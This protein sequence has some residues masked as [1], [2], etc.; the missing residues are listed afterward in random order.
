[1][2]CRACAG[3]PPDGARFCPDCGVRLEPSQSDTGAPPPAQ[4]ELRRITVLFC[5]LVGS[6]ELSTHMDAEEFGDVI[7]RYHRAVETVVDL[8]DGTVVQYLGDGVLA[9]FGWP[10][11]HDDDAEH[12]V[13][14]AVDITDAVAAAGR[15]L[16]PGLRLAVRVGVHSGPVMVGQLGGVRR[17]RMAL[18][19][20]MNLAARVQQV[21]P[22]GTAVMTDA[23][24]RMVTG[25][26]VI[27]DLGEHALKG[28]AEPVPVYRVVQPSGVRSHFDVI[29]ARMTPLVGRADELGALVAA[30][31]Q[32]R[33]G[34]GAAVLVSG[35][36]GIGKS[37]L[38]YELRRQLGQTP[39]SWLEARCS[40]YT[41][42]SAFRPATELIERGLGLSPG[43]PPERRLAV[44]HAVMGRN[45]I[46][47]PEAVPLLAALIS[48]GPP[49]P[50]FATPEQRRT[51]TLEVVARWVRA[52]A[53]A[54]PLV[55]FVEDLHWADP[56]TLALF[57][58]LA[59]EAVG[60][61]V[62]LIGTARPGFTPPTDIPWPVEQLD[63][64]ALG[65]EETRALVALLGEGAQVPDAVID[66][67]TAAAEGVPLFAEEVGRMLLEATGRTGD[68]AT[69]SVPERLPVPVTLHD[70][71]MARLDRVEVAKRVAQYAAVIGGTFDDAMLA[72]IADLDADEVRVGLDHLVEDRI[73]FRRGEPPATVY[74]F[75]HALLEEAAYGS[76]LR[77]SRRDLHRRAATELQ[78]RRET[79]DTEPAFE[80]IAQHWE[81]AGRPD[82]AVERYLEAAW[83][84]ALRS[85]HR[86]AAVHLR[87]ALELLE[88]EPGAAEPA[89]LERR[90]ELLLTTAR[91]SWW[92]GEFHVARARYHEAADIAILQ[93]LPRQLARAALGY[94]GRMGFGA[95][96]RD[97]TLVGLLEA[98]LGALDPCETALRAQVTARLAEAITFSAPTERRAQLC[99]EA[100]LLAAESGDP[101]VVAAVLINQH[102]AVWDVDTLGQ[103]LA[104]ARRVVALASEAED[105]VLECEGRM[106]L[107]ADLTEAG[108]M[109]EAEREATAWEELA[110]TVSDGYQLWAVA[111]R[112]AMRH[113]LDGD[114]VAAEVAAGVALETGQRGGNQNA[115]Q[116]YGVQIAHV[117]RE[118]DRMAELEGALRDLIGHY[119]GITTWRCALAVLLA[120]NDRLEEAR[121]EF[122]VLADTPFPR[123][124]FW[125]ANI[126][127]AAD[128]CGRLGEVGAAHILAGRLRPYRRQAVTPGPFTVCWGSTSRSLGLLAA[129]VGDWDVAD[130]L[131][132][133]AVEH[134]RELGARLWEVRTQIDWAEMLVARGAPGDAVRARRLLDAVSATADGLGLERRRREA[135]ALAVRLVALEAA[136]PA[137]EGAG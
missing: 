64:E 48:A 100:A 18:G 19:A 39:H 34:T 71:L 95:G 37:R 110:A 17:E 133:E 55:L 112:R 5:D 68:E 83:D 73:L 59:A 108:Q 26:F 82:L 76:L 130:E 65:T 69:G 20:T 63:V 53:G 61:R 57:G 86:E 88:H 31:E 38:V 8:Y 16:S 14:A 4:G 131:F 92:A 25:L 46:E 49:A 6:T 36:P 125:L 119:T 13:R 103:R 60:A 137:R 122:Q 41:A 77:R 72:A 74:T 116:I 27:E 44:L 120:D 1:M 7:A 135:R 115:L 43:D 12:A 114:L 129:T 89:A 136:V 91:S 81:E 54:Q 87:R 104:I 23:T 111:A 93:A 106:W 28:F 84:S 45:S 97:E 70:S 15:E 126:V 124:M 42:R 118:Q 21:A 33:A 67:V 10:A 2:R 85:G 109:E 40:A 75:K 102:W 117:R 52:L 94:G 3:R 30:W 127:L 24:R 56:S 101:T 107:V 62:L 66:R 98:A 96:F 80:R 32:A 99:A 132:A 79:G 9:A 105:A 22:P 47:D 123:D 58:R 50:A 35:E 134:N 11:A 29:G 51:L 128:A 78:R 113:L 121:A 90:C